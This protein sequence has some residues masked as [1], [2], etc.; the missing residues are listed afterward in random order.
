MSMRIVGDRDLLKQIT[1]LKRIFPNEA[2]LI[3]A[4]VALV[5]IET[6]AKKT[7]IPVDT[8]RLRNSIH[9]EFIEG[10]AGLT[11]KSTVYKD[12][13]GES[14]NGKLSAS[15]DK[16]S[17]VVGTN[18][19]YA[20]K[21]NRVGGGGKNSKR[22]FEGKKRPKG[23]GQRFWDKA[24]KNGESSLIRELTDLTRRAGGLV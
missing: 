18:V 21:I 16:K 4:E 19:E 20:D 2:N 8:G 1:E 5:D 12:D 24:I 14:F 9:T 3:V 15:L 17:V 13:K 11:P 10:F 22:E 7:E 23:Y 6:Y